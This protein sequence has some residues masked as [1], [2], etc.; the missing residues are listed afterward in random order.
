MQDQIVLCVAET[1]FQ[2][3]LTNMHT[4][5]FINK[6]CQLENKRNKPTPESCISYSNENTYVLSISEISIFTSFVKYFIYV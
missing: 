6:K 4:Q 3:N 2:V 5:L 1:K